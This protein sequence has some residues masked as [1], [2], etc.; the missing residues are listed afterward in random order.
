MNKDS[1]SNEGE[2]DI[3]V[4][5]IEALRQSGIKDTDI[6]VITPY[7]AQVYK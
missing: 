3:V 4:K 1:K 5:H 6:A 7:N 2:A